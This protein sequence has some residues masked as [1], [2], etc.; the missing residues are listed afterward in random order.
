MNRLWVVMPVYNEQACIAAVVE[1]WLAALRGAASDFTLCVLNDGSTD[2]TPRIL[3][4]MASRE[5]ELVVIDRPNSGHG[6]TCVEG[7]RTALAHGAE[8][9]LQ[10]DSDGQCDAGLLPLFV[11]ASSQ[12]PVTYGCRRIRRD[13]RWRH[14]ISRAVSVCVYAAT[15][16]WVRDP[17]V[18]YR[19]MDA[20]TLRDVVDQVPPDF[21]LANVLVAVLQHRR[22]GIHWVDIH[23]RPRSAGT[24][25]V[26]PLGFV[27][28]GVELF[29]QL[30]RWSGVRSR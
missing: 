29:R 7:Y 15:G 24:S 17:N 16:V 23:F 8:W 9:I 3:H 18:P 21:H 27:T 5:R 13:G 11:T 1:E 19:V 25:S 10:V 20:S 22:H 6:Q 12:Y 26:K 14:L 2:G 30:R 4:E 28:R